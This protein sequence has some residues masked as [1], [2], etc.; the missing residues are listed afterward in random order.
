[1]KTKLAPTIRSKLVLLVMACVVPAA[2]MAV[3][4]ITHDYQRARDQLLLNSLSTARAMVSVVDRDFA[5]IESSLITLATS[6]YLASNNLHAFYNQAQDVLKNQ[7]DQDGINIVLSDSQGNQYLNT[8][9]AFGSTLPPHTEIIRL[10]ELFKNEQPVISDLFFGTV[11]KQNLFAITVPVP[12]QR[13]PRFSL[14]AGVLPARMD[15]LLQQ[16]HIPEGW[17][18]AIFDSTGTIVARTGNRPEL[19]GKKGVPEIVKRMRSTNE[20]MFES[21][22]YD[23]T[24][25]QTVFSRSKLSNWALAIGIP[26]QD[27][28]HELRN[29]LFL[30]ILATIILLACSVAAAWLIGGRIADSI[31][32]LTGPALAL[33]AGKLVSVPPLHLREADEVGTSLARASEMLHQAQHQANHDVLTGLANRALFHE[34][35]SQQ[36]ALCERNKTVL[37]ILYIDLDGFKAVNDKHGHEAGDKLLRAVASRLK[38]NSRHSDVVARLGGDEFAMVMVGAHMDNA[39]FVAEK[40][41]EAISAP[42]VLDDTL[43][44][45]ISASIG[46]ATYPESGTTSEALLH[47]ADGAMYKA[48]NLGRRRVALATPH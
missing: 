40:M 6:P 42:Y 29:T 19:I 31:H 12:G 18:A 33:G 28:M 35:V 26:T 46:V 34:I 10:E 9:Q 36:L 21:V 30:L 39:R 8:H 47:R 43:T 37:S 4:L 38:T 45:H 2:L 22:T 14:S 17:I 32:G 3:L 20:D 41:V 44:S 13:D 48:K 1:M 15:K 16:Q 5:S 27:I 11:S 23:G 25:V 24:A 7:R